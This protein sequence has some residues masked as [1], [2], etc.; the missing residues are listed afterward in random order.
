MKTESLADQQKF[1]LQYIL[2]LLWRPMPFLSAN[3]KVLKST[4]NPI[5]TP[6]R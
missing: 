3:F 4:P 1:R 2:G 5:L 6:I